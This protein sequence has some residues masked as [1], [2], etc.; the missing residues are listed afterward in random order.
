ML[1]R[2]LGTDLIIRKLRT[3][4][5]HMATAAEQLNQ[6][7]AAVQDI[8]N[9]VRVLLNEDREAFSEEGQAAFDRLQARL[10]DLD[11]EVG[12]RDGSDTPPVEPTEPPTT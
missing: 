11:V 1:R 10:S 8:A 4:E 6:L 2:L 9:D 5:E 3:M 7:N 12:D